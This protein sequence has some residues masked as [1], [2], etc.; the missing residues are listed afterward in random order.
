[1][2]KKLKLIYNPEDAGKFYKSKKGQSSKQRKY[3]LTEDEIKVLQER[4]KLDTESVPDETKAKAGDYFFNP[5]R[6]GIYWAQLQ[7][8]Y[9]LGCNEWHEFKDILAK[10]QQIASAMPATIKTPNGML[11][12]NQWEKFRRRVPKDGATS[13]KSLLGRI[14]ENF[15]FM[16]RLSCHH[17]SGYKLMQAHASLDMKKVSKEGFPGGILFYRLQIHP[18]IDESIPTRDL[19]EYNFDAEE[20][21]YYTY[22]F[23]GKVI[24]KDSVMECEDS[25]DHIEESV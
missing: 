22:K 21:R 8:L 10:T 19:S 11:S 14:Q 6:K 3:H 13:S 17:P 4:H 7:A 18:T 15:T 9:L 23:V 24:T 20:K 12:T 2:T 1:M 16:Q 25:I 5:Y